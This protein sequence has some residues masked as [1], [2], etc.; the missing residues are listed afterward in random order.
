MTDKP[1]TKD[2][3]IYIGGLEPAYCTGDIQSAKR[4][5]KREMLDRGLRLHLDIIDGWFNIPDGDDKE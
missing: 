3:E 5:V 2:M 1:L 4:G